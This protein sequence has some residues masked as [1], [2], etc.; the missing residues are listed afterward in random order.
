MM[1]KGA[2]ESSIVLLLYIYRKI[3]L[4]ISLCVVSVRKMYRPRVRAHKHCIFFL[5]QSVSLAVHMLHGQDRVIYMHGTRTHMSHVFAGDHQTRAQK[6]MSGSTPNYAWLPKDLD[7]QQQRCWVVSDISMAQG[8][9]VIQRRFGEWS[10][11][12]EVEP[13]RAGTLAGTAE[14][15]I[16]LLGDFLMQQPYVLVKEA[17]GDVGDVDERVR[18]HRRCDTETTGS[19][20]V[21]QTALF[22]I[23]DFYSDTA[24]WVQRVYLAGLCGNVVYNTALLAMIRQDKDSLKKVGRIFVIQKAQEAFMTIARNVVAISTFG[25]P[26]DPCPA[27]VGI[28]NVHDTA[29]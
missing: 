24:L 25:A 19:K 12:V 14:E 9:L 13:L 8:I 4:S 6:T 10:G 17:V 21:Q 11:Q 16:F 3:Y 18:K 5:S 22:R 1:T 29:T 2:V 23:L 28:C 26:R 7:M 20:S 27:H 15:P